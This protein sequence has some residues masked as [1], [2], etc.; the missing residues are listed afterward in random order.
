MYYVIVYLMKNLMARFRSFFLKCLFI[1][2]FTSIPSIR[3]DNFFWNKV[4]VI[5][6]F[7]KT[8]LYVI[9][10]ISNPVTDCKAFNINFCPGLFALLIDLLIVHIY[11]I[12]QVGYINTSI[13]FACDIKRVILMIPVE[14][15]VFVIKN[16]HSF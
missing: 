4:K 11:V 13:A 3:V 16:F 7:W 6:S 2:I 14:S 15:R 8:W 1:I 10:P 9:F 12:G 5:K